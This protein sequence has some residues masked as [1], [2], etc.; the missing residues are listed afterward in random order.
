MARVMSDLVE[1]RPT[2]QVDSLDVS[3]PIWFIDAPLQIRV[4][5]CQPASL[6]R[7]SWEQKHLPVSYPFDSQY[8]AGI[9]GGI[10]KLKG[11][12]GSKSNPVSVDRSPAFQI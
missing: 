6:L 3:P 12:I 5:P 1:H 4:M 8:Q 9:V 2:Q 11:Q 10:V 7:I